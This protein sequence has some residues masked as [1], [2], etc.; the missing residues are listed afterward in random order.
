MVTHKTPA[1]PNRRA[2]DQHTL[3]EMQLAVLAYQNIPA[4]LAVN[5]AATLGA[6]LLL[7]SDGVSYIPV[8][9]G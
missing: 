8:W 5:V 4:M 1:F 9:L 7:H 3:I 2:T 6:A